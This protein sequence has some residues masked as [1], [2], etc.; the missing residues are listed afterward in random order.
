MA[1]TGFKPV[2]SCPK[3]KSPL[4]QEGLLRS[5]KDLLRTSSTKLRFE[6]PKNKK[7]LK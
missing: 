4:F 7:V 5:Q 6:N 1:S 2:T 3:Q